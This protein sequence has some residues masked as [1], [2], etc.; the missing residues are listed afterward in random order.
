MRLLVAKW[1]L[2]IGPFLRQRRKT[3]QPPLE[4]NVDR[5]EYAG[6]DVKDN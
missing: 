6:D 1:Y 2:N 3:A 4:A 5:I